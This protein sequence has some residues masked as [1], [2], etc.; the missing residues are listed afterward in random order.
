MQ[1]R[2]RRVFSVVRSRLALVLGV[3]AFLGTRTDAS[4]QTRWYV[5]ALTGVS[6]LSADARSRFEPPDSS[7]FSLYNPK[8]GSAFSAIVGRDVS[9]YVSL[10]GNYVWNRNRLTLT[11]GAISSGTL[12]EYA[13]ERSSSQ[14]SAI[15]D[16]MVYFRSRDS[17][18]RP[19]FSVGTGWVHFSSTEQHVT[20]S[21]GMPVLPPRTFSSNLIAL[22]VP[23]GIDVG[24]AKGWK[25]RYA[26]SETLTRNPISDRLSPP[27]MHRLMNFESLFGVVRQF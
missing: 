14:H 18:F 21:N 27:G 16:V 10:Q 6:T 3:F 12:T 1:P 13:E 23:V 9:E 19:Y 5:G 24:L 26:F 15:A 7:A 25:F 8:N 20:K 4:A 22:H 17:R 2:K 11:S